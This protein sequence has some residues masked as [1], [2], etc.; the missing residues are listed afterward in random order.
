MASINDD[1][2]AINTRYSSELNTSEQGTTVSSWDGDDGGGYG[3][4]DGYYGEDGEGIYGYPPNYDDEPDGLDY[5]D[6]SGNYDED[7]QND[8][9]FIGQNSGR[10]LDL[11]PNPVPRRVDRALAVIDNSISRWG[12]VDAL[13][14]LGTSSSAGRLRNVRQL[15]IKLGTTVFNSARKDDIRA[16]LSVNRRTEILTVIDLEIVTET[17]RGIKQFW[18]ALRRYFSGT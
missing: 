17:D 11:L 6:P 13:L 2:Y 9:Q 15:L 4:D 14:S 5:E 16:A 8:G 1:L 3:R 10:P 18:V 12:L 7:F